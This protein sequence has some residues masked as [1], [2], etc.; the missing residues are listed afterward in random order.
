MSQPQRAVFF[1]D[2]PRNVQGAKKAR[3]QLR[4]ARLLLCLSTVPVGGAEWEPPAACSLSA[5]A[6]AHCA[7]GSGRGVRGGRRGGGGA[8]APLQLPQSLSN[9]Q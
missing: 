1:D 5:G 7:R 6:S 2:S 4:Q 9:L 8:H 3:L